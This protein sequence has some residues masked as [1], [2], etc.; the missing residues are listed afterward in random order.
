MEDARS[1]RFR[2]G[3]RTCSLTL[4]GQLPTRA[5]LAA[6]QHRGC[7]SARFGQPATETRMAE[8][9]PKRLASKREIVT[10]PLDAPPA[11]TRQR[12]GGTFLVIKG[13]D[14]GESVNLREKPIFFGSS[15]ASDLV[16]T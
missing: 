13:P 10:N 8:I 6:G 11:F 5:S 9:C 3:R 12:A 7:A 14:R 2:C 4:P 16:L 1:L 15:P